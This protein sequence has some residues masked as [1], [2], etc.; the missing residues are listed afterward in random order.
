MKQSLA[1]GKQLSKG[2]K[3]PAIENKV[4]GVKCL[5]RSQKIIRSAV[6]ERRWHGIIVTYRNCAKAICGSA[7]RMWLAIGGAVPLD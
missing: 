4:C 5:T 1:D 3:I 2:H 7:R 6:P